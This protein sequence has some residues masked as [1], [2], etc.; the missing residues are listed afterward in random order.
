ML[1]LALLFADPAPP[2]AALQDYIGHCWLTRIDDVTTDRHCFSRVYGGAHVRDTHVVSR[3]GQPVYQGETLF[4]DE[5]GQLSFTYWNSLG[6]I[7]RGTA[8]ASGN[9]LRFSLVMRA[10][11][12]SAPVTSSFRWRLLDDGYETSGDGV[13]RH[14]ARDDDGED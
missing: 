13:V 1:M 5:A 6:G 10:A 2:L 14:F 8:L 7:G 4:S 3:D 9:E 11:P 12:G